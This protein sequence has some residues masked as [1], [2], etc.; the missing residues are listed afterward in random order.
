MFAKLNFIKTEFMSIFGNKKTLSVAI[1]LTF[2]AILV[3]SLISIIWIV[4]KYIWKY[5]TVEHFAVGL[6]IL[7]TTRMFIV[8]LIEIDDK[9]G[10]LLTNYKNTIDEK[11]KRIAE[12]EKQLQELEEKSK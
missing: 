5:M 4:T 9:I 7:I 12:L 10:A 1:M 8:L 2:D 6:V 3:G 11:S